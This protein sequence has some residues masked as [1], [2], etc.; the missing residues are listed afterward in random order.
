[1]ARRLSTQHPE[2]QDNDRNER[3]C[4]LHESEMRNEIRKV[5]YK[6]ERCQSGREYRTRSVKNYRDLTWARV[7]SHR[8]LTMFRR[9]GRRPNPDGLSQSVQLHEAASPYSH[10]RYHR[11]SAKE[12]LI[13]LVRSAATGRSA[14][15]STRVNWGLRLPSNPAHSIFRFACRLGRGSKV[16]GRYAFGQVPTRQKKRVRSV[17]LVCT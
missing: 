3:A 5:C 2:H 12:K 14:T 9:Q 4:S 16:S 15:V 8:S 7:V 17:T 13:P 10:P 6:E 11:P 1:M